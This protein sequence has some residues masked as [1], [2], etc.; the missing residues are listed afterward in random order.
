MPYPVA[1]VEEDYLRTS[2][3]SL[4]R[5]NGASPLTGISMTVNK[6][7]LPDVGEGLTEAEIV[8]HGR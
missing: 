1:K 3:A 6:F 2:T 5:W 8:V 7:N 4:R